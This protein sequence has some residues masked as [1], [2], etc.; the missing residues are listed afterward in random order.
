MKFIQITDLHMIPEGLL[1]GLDPEER[2]RACIEDINAKH[3]DAAHVVVTGDLTHGGDEESY[4]RL[5]GILAGLRLPTHLLI[6][7]HDDRA[8]FR[9]VFSSAPTDSAGFIQFTFDTPV[10]RFVCL[11]TKEGPHHGV[12]S[13]ERLAWLADEMNHA[14]D[15]PVYLFMHHPPF[16]VGIRRMDEIALHD[17]DRF[18][19]IVTGRRNLR[20]LFFGH[21]HRPISGVW[22]GIPFANMPGMNHQV[23]LD[24]EIADH[25]PGSCEPP[26]YAVVF[27]EAES[28]I[29][30]LHNFLDRSNTFNL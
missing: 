15:R 4:R 24:F 23:A 7:N 11:D 29:V 28:T 17:T 18:A 27:A 21:L 10:G 19:A 9:R 25:V 3:S 26:A 6:G 2:L 20:H 30:H 5:Q 1:Y 13:E 12:L 8:T 14:G 22:H 16:A